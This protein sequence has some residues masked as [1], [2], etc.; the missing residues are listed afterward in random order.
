MIAWSLWAML[1]FGVSSK[2]CGIA[3]QNIIKTVFKRN[4]VPEG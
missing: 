3:C 2:V 1:Q 4:N